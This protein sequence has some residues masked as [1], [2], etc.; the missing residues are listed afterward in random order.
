ML[1]L[2]GKTDCSLCDK[3]KAALRAANLEFTEVNVLEDAAVFERYQ[4]EIPVLVDSNGKELLKG[5]FTEARVAGLVAR[6]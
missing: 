5:V 1:M 3:A 2:Y 6:L 4:Y